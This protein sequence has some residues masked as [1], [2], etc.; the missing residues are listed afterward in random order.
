MRR[1]GG[2]SA[3]PPACTGVRRHDLAHIGGHV[4]GDGVPETPVEPGE[5][6]PPLVRPHALI[7]VEECEDADEARTGQGQD[8]ALFFR[9]ERLCAVMSRE[10]S[11]SS[12]R[13]LRPFSISSFTRAT[14]HGGTYLQTCL[15]RP[16]FV[17]NL[18]WGLARLTVPSLSAYCFRL[19]AMEPSANSVMDEISAAISRMRFATELGAVF[20]MVCQYLR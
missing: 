3:F 20:F 18:N 2:A 11:A 7:L 13:Y 12:L 10:Y 17:W 5:F 19:L 15:P 8:S 14:A 16:P 9:D 1:C 6:L 4:V